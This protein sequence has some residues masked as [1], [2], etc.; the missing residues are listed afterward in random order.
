M[1]KIEKLKAKR[2]DLRLQAVGILTRA[3]GEDRFL[4]DD[5]NKQVKGIEDEIARA[6]E[7]IK[8]SEAIGNITE[9]RLTETADE[10]TNQTADKRSFKQNPQESER[11]FKSFGEQLKAIYR[12]SAPGARVDERLTTRAASGLNE[13]N[14]TDGGFLV[15]QDFVSELLKRTFDTGVLA[16][17]VRRVPISTN[18]NGLK[19]NAVD[20]DHRKDGCRWGGVQTFWESEADAL[21]GS[22]PKFRQ[23]ELNLKKLTGLCYATDELLQDAAALESVIRQ[24]FTEEFAFKID[25]AIIGGSGAGQPLGILK[26]KALVVQA[27]EQGQTAKVT[28]DNLIKMWSRLWGRSRANSVWYVNQEIEPLLY[29]LT[30]GDKPVYIPA[31]GLSDTPY[32]TLFGRP[33]VPLEQ[34]SAL[35]E[36]GDILLADISQYMLIDKGGINAQSSIHCRFL[37]DEEVF[38]F[39]YRSDGQPIWNKPI[40]PYKGSATL[41]PFVALA[42]RN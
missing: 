15:Q 4:T 36:V 30:V 42:A 10:D 9:Q 21:T 8:R 40:T 22:K 33:V 17:K 14:P 20:D 31:G 6:D 26:S 24:A 38:R 35:G 28:V 34:C 29:T 39:I 25:D 12:S 1:N 16:G 11:A 18:A 41:S 27:L 23:I 32:A 5:E 37:Y 7:S 2:E 19:I 13:T 3:E